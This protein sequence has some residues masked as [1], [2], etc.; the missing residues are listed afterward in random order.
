VSR[1]R[2]H[3]GYYA[4]GYY[5]VL[6][7]VT[8][9]IG[10][11][12]AMRGW[13]RVG[14]GVLLY[15]CVEGVGLWLGVY[16]LP[17]NRVRRAA[18]VAALLEEDSVARILDLGSGRGLLAIEFAKR[19]GA[20][21]VVAVDIWQRRVRRRVKGFDPT[22]PVLR[23]AVER[24]RENARIEGVAE[25]IDF[26]TCD[27][28]RLALRGNAFDVVTCAFLLFHLYRGVFRRDD[29]PRRT[30][31]GE[32]YRTLRA[33][34][35]LVVFE[36]VTTSWVNALAWTPLGYVGMR[37][38]SKPLTVGYWE[39]LLRESGF[40]VER[41]ELYRGNVVFVARKEAVEP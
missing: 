27:A 11:A 10:I 14:G 40:V 29:T 5:V 37:L 38:L 41:T 25:R 9:L 12:L 39:S 30:C 1:R 28:T 24:T 3:Y 6:I 16:V 34:G 32:A 19:F 31:L 23:H 33:G 15:G 17:E 2:P 36:L 7:G 8:L 13:T 22:A 18:R 35:R 21:R 26:V 4:L 20:S